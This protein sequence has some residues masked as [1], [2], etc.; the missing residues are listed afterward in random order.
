MGKRGRPLKTEVPE[1]NYENIVIEYRDHEFSLK[2]IAERYN[3]TPYIIKQILNNAG[4]NIK[5]QGRQPKRKNVN[6]H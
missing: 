4:I 6:G 1:E 2:L 3:T 5:K